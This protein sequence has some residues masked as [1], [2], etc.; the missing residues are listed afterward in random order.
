MTLMGQICEYKTKA[1]DFIGS[2]PVQTFL[3]FFF[4]IIFQL[5][6][7]TVRE[8]LEL[9]FSNRIQADFIREPFDSSH[10]CFNDIR[11]QADIYEWGNASSRRSS[12]AATAQPMGG[13][14]NK[15]CNDHGWP[16]GEGGFGRRVR[17]VIR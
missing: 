11:R 17:A 2:L 8:P 4:V 16:D 1:I 6:A 10:N 13:E 15:T 3:Y 14:G 5:L 9:Y 12:A 7:Y